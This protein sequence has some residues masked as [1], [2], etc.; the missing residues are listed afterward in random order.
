MSAEPVG[1]I[2]TIAQ[3][4]SSDIISSIIK[5]NEDKFNDAI[6]QKISAVDVNVLKM[7]CNLLD[8]HLLKSQPPKLTTN[9]LNK[10]IVFAII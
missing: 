10:L 2:C 8:E 3:R 5:C 1:E 4:R 9:Q 6:H 7:T